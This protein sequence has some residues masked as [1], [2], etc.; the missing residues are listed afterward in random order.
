MF[1]IKASAL[2]C[3]LECSVLY[4]PIHLTTFAPDVQTLV[5]GM[6]NLMS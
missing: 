4:T 1:C 2:R 3:F 6:N 5:A